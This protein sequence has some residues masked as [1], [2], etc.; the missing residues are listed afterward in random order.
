MGHALMEDWYQTLDYPV[1]PEFA[2]TSVPN[3]ESLEKF[4]PEEEM[5][6]PGLSW[7]HHWADLDRLRMQNWDAFN[8]QKTGSLQEFVDAT[9]DAQG[10][11][12]QNGVEYF[13][14]Q[15]PSLSGIALCHFITYWPDIKWGIIDNYQKPKRS[16]E[17]VKRAYQP[18]LISLHFNKRRWHNDESFVGEIWVI[19][20][21][22]ETYKNCTV[23]LEI[24]DDSG[25]SLKKSEFNISKIAE[26]SAAKFFVINEDVLS[27]IEKQFTVHLKLKNNTD[28]I[29]SA[30][31][32]LFLIGDQAEASAQFKEM[33]KAIVQ[34]NSKYTYGNYYRFFPKMIREDGR[35][36]Q[37]DTQHPKA[38]G[39]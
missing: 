27:S 16:Y 24:K 5:W 30:N 17:F 37:S 35:D 36:H 31:E 32:Y 29:L 12:F 18:L 9:Q 3:V 22:Y 11:I 25:N 26:N 4:I 28:E 6:P 14:R 20:D 15:K 1:V 7:G 13:R 21:L 10:I 39:F 34:K 2:I 19:N 33:R 38:K 23:E 8:D